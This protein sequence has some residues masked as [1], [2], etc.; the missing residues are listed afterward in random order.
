MAGLVYSL[1]HYSVLKL[2]WLTWGRGCT[3]LYK[4][5]L[6]KQAGVG[7]E[8]EYRRPHT[9]YRTILEKFGGHHMVQPFILGS[10]YSL[11]ASN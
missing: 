10:L 11:W 5:I 9:N 2:E 4:L 8:R 1:A 6:G 7:V 3:R